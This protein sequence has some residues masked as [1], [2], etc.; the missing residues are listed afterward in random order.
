[1]SQTAPT[2]RERVYTALSFSEPDVC[3]YYIWIDQEMVGPLA[4]HYQDPDFRETYVR[5]HTV[6]VEVLAGREPQ[7]DGTYRDEFGTL[8]RQG[9]IPHIVRPALCEPSLEGYR[10]PDLATDAHFAH[11]PEWIERYQDRF[12]IVQLGMLFFERTWAM[13]GFENVLVDF[14]ESPKFVDELLHGLEQV[15]L[16]AI[17]RLLLQYG[18]RIDAIGFS[19][20]T[21]GEHAMLLS[22]E[23]WRRI[24]KPHLRRMFGRI[25]QAGKKAYFHSCGNI[26]PIV[27]D[28][29]DIGVDMLQPLQPESMDI[30]ELKREFG[31]DLCLVGGISTQKT[32]PFG[33]PE[34]VVI[35]V[36]KCLEHMAPGGGYVMAPAKPIMPGVPLANATALIDSIV[37]QR[38]S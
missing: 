20:D 28:L 18:D 31:R 19:D 38:P 14:Y 25:R 7:P 30:F 33:T 26:R 11:L 9:N 35:E 22:P 17:E 8:W 23:M 10:F 5:D 32:L 1:M 2:P 16:R 24:L 34:D 21:G 36:G 37:Q 27:P 3:P 13:R 12:R 4:E 6:M 15:S 29:I